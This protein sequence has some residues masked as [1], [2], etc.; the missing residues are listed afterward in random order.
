VRELGECPVPLE[1]RGDGINHGKHAGR[2]CWCVTGTLCQGRVQ[3]T[4]AQ[5][6]GN[7]KACPF[8]QFV[9]KE[10]GMNFSLSATILA[11]LNV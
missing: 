10:E 5:K 4:F 7:C 6:F 2:C 11:R 9:K 1:S 3:G 8:Y